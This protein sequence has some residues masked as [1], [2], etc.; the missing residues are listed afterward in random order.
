MSCGSKFRV[1]DNLSDKVV[2]CPKCGN[3]IKVSADAGPTTGKTEIF[4]LKDEPETHITA[5][6]SPPKPSSRKLPSGTEPKRVKKATESKTEVQKSNSKMLLGIAIAGATIGLASLGALGVIF[7]KKDSNDKEPVAQAQ[8]LATA[9]P[10][11]NIPEARPAEPKALT[12]PIPP[13]ANHMVATPKAPQNNAPAP[14]TAHSSGEQVY[15]RLLKSAVYVRTSKGSGTGVLVDRVNRLA[16]TCQHVVE[17]EPAVIVLFPVLQNGTLIASEA[18]TAR[19]LKRSDVIRAKVVATEA[20]RDLALIQLDSVPESALPVPISA[21]VASPG[22]NVHSIGNP[23][24]SKAMW[25]YTSGSIR[26]IYQKNWRDAGGARE[27]WVVETQSPIN[28]GDS[29]GPLVNDNCQLLGI[30]SSYRADARLVSTFIES[31]E[32]RRMLENYSQAFGVKLAVENAAGLGTANVA[33]ND[34]IAQL[35]H[36]DPQTRAKAVKALDDLGPEAKQALPALLKLLKDQDEGLRR[37]AQKALDAI[38]K[39]AKVDVPLLTSALKD[40]S[41]LV[42]AYAAEALGSIGSDASLASRS[43]RDAVMDK[44]A[45]VQQNATIALARIGL[46]PTDITPELLDALKNTDIETR[47]TAIIAIAKMGADA[48]VA[49]PFLMES[50]NSPAKAI[51]ESAVLALGSIGAAAKPALPALKKLLTDEDEQTR[52]S[53]ARALTEVA[54]S[55]TDGLTVLVQ[56]LRDRP[57]W[58]L[59][60][61]A[62]IAKIGPGAEPIIPDLVKAMR[63]PDRAVC[64]K[65]AETIGSVG[66]SAKGAITALIENLKE[67]KMKDCCQRALERIGKAAVPS[68]TDA[69]SNRNVAIRIG[70]A[71]ALGNIGSDARS[72]MTALAGASRDKSKEVREAARSALTKIQQK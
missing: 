59:A 24:S 32:V 16:V 26:Q 1:P 8:A 11:A 20:S 44:D 66:Q 5:R 69:M 48:K 18:D 50:L 27:A 23:A 45:H 58:K 55:D 12:A 37:S 21:M 54:P 33:V 51:R 30:T 15:K 43:L 25:L 64:T 40:E 41:P 39:P 62:Q 28:P 3:S 63:D 49:I 34:L 61:L 31:R 52:F 10:T 72:A 60:A 7:L 29:G 47:R 6:P 4:R 70:A 65:A 38:G 57:E 53:A 19:A 35:A 42:R 56:A 67:P 22:Q 13:A 71:E 2:K 46:Q 14:A 36:E 17:R 68:L 9:S